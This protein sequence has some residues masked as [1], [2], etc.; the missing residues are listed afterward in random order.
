MYTTYK[1]FGNLFLSAKLL[2]QLTTVYHHGFV[3]S[4]YRKKVLKKSFK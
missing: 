3:F 1:R 2:Y 4:T